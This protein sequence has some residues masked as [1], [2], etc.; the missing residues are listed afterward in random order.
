MDF[1]VERGYTEP[2]Q[3]LAA[4][5]YVNGIRNE[6][7]EVQKEFKVAKDILRTESFNHVT[8]I[9]LATGTKFKTAVSYLINKK[10]RLTDADLW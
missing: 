10:I 7:A 8:G 5:K 1:E 2:L 4:I 9:K 3:E 6:N